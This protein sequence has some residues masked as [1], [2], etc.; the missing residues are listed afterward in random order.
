MIPKLKLENLELSKMVCGTN[1]F[2]AITHR[3]NPLDML[4]HV[5][6]FRDSKTVAKFM[7]F[8]QQE[9]GV[10]CCVSSPR[11]KV[12][13]AIQIT[14]KETG[15]D[16][17]W[18]CTPSRRRS[19]DG[20]EP[21]IWKQ[22]D[23]CVDH[24]VSVCGPHRS[25]TDKCINYDSLEIGGTGEKYPPLGEITEY[26][27]DRDMIPMIS[28]HYIETIEAVEKQGYDIKLIIQPLNQIGFE[29]NTEPEKLIEKINST[30]LQILNIK[31]M[32]AGRLSPDVLTWNLENI[33]D[34]DFLAVG[35]GKYK[36]CVED[37][38]IIDDFLSNNSP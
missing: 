35:F 38:K 6:R 12:Y 14:E 19:A 23:W 9:Y 25:Y 3:W 4:A 27:R 15:E 11:D 5:I 2:V 17:H 24:N 16:F 10:N 30:D 31:P 18:I 32:A 36:Y 8:L 37:A 22:I 34:N 29:S 26:I 7:I 20:I 33:K 13:E 21:D 1:Q 28:T